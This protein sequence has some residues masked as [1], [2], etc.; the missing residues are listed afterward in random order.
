[1]GFG[2]A[3]ISVFNIWGALTLLGYALTLLLV[4]RVV[5][6][7]KRNPVSTI[8]WILA[9]ILLPYLGGLLFLIFG[10]NR[11]ERRAAHKYQSSRTIS[12]RL[13]ELSQFQL[14]VEEGLTPQQQ[15]LMRLTNSVS[16]MH[17]TFG[18][19]IEVLDD[20]NRTLGLIEQAI[21]SATET[22]HLEYYIWQPDK[23][24]TR[25]RDLLIRKANDGLIIRFLYDGIGSMFLTNRFL[26]PMRDAGIHVASFLPGASFRERWSLN[27]RSHRKIV[28]V[29]GRVGF[30]GG[31]NIGDE[32]IGKDPET[33]FWRDT[34]L[35]L[36]GPS[37][38]QLQQIFVED[39]L[40]ATGEELTHPQIFP[41]P[42]DM[43]DVSAQVLAGGPDNE[44]HVFLSLMFAAI[45]EARES[46]TLATSY[47][48]PPVSIATALETAGYRGV[49]VR[50]LL[51]GRAGY[52]WTWLAGRSYYDSLMK[53]GV[54]I[55]EYDR[56]LLHSKTL[57]IDGAWSLVGSP[58]VDSRSLLLNF[59]DAV[60][61]YDDRIAA[62]LE[63]Q[64]AKDLR[65]A[66]RINAETW[67]Q[68]KTMHILGENLCRLFAPVL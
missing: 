30:T 15:R 14:M 68:R 37:V 56:G 28:V 25:L 64:F 3:E 53:A 61:M 26:K 10:I 44:V 31:M 66:N 22:L 13:S 45:N 39:W 40:Y 60:A 58:N 11:V 49:K 65:R 50:L 34:H 48:V 24:G 18:N 52:S 2:F 38:L 47:F 7:K 43:G 21:L 12:G 35:R 51:S 16:G 41:R 32:Y 57:T 20:T 46:V 55:Y 23:T 42:E 1:M 27:L 29:D 6:I 54:E 9:V 17:P 8:A 5:L 63:D 67:P 62:Q 59:E 19:R 4:P 33:G 36:Y